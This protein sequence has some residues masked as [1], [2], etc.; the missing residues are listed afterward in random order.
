MNTPQEALDWLIALGDEYLTSSDNRD[1]YD[2][3]R[4]EEAVALISASMATPNEEQLTETI[5]QLMK[6][7]ED[8]V[9]MFN[10]HYETFNIRLRIETDKSAQSR[11]AVALSECAGAISALGSILAHVMSEDADKPTKLTDIF[12]GLGLTYP[13]VLKTGK[14]L[15]LPPKI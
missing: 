11:L 15:V 5:K 13:K 8:G 10:S 3:K 7:I 14:K 9:G 12:T 4:L 2:L 1:E 6:L